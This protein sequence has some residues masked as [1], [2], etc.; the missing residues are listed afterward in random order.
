MPDGLDTI[1][2]MIK[3]FK[4]IEAIPANASED[5]RYYADLTCLDGVL[6]KVGKR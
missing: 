6:A 2:T 4:T 3:Y 5:P 1:R